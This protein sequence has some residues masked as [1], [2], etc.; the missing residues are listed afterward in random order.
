MDTGGDNPQDADE[1]SCGDIFRDIYATEVVSAV[2]GNIARAMESDIANTAQSVDYRKR[3]FETASVKLLQTAWKQSQLRQGMQSDDIVSTLVTVMKVEQALLAACSIKRFV[4]FEHLY[5]E[6]TWVGNNV[7]NM[8][9]CVRSLK[10][11]DVVAFRCFHQMANIL[12]DIQYYSVLDELTRAATSD[13]HD[14]FDAWGN[15]IKCGTDIDTLAENEMK[16]W[17]ST[18]SLSSFVFSISELQ[19]PKKDGAVDVH[20]V[21]MIAHRLA[22][23]QASHAR[24]V[25]K[26]TKEVPELAEKWEKTLIDVS[27]EPRIVHLIMEDYSDPNLPKLV[28]FCGG[29]PLRKLLASGVAELYSMCYNPMYSSTD[30]IQTQLL[31][32]LSHN[33]FTKGFKS[34]QAWIHNEEQIL[35]ANTSGTTWANQHEQSQKANEKKTEEKNQTYHERANQIK[36]S[37][38]SVV[39][40]T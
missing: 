32:V 22:E 8:L 40:K 34:C 23:V 31:A 11:R 20:K 5:I 38:V 3:R 16:E 4:N 26:V 10:S 6:Q 37:I 35:Y 27:N 14:A 24:R 18:A 17:T 21:K 30:A 7:A 12:S 15:G 25:Y 29:G 33:L 19:I 2:F 39:I 9:R 13:D 1:S 28:A 36:T